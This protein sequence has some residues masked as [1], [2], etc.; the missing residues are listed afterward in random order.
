MPWDTESGGSYIWVTVCPR[1]L[2]TVAATDET[3]P[4]TCL[5]STG[6]ITNEKPS[7]ALPRCRTLLFPGSGHVLGILQE[8]YPIWWLRICALCNLTETLG[9]SVSY[10]KLHVVCGRWNVTKPDADLMPW[11][12]DPLEV[13]GSANVI[14]I[15]DLQGVCWQIKLVPE[16]RSEGVCL[17]SFPSLCSNL[18]SS[19]FS[20]FD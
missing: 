2:R 9:L 8:E 17:N 1:S 14:S 20:V 12:D 11:V 19:F 6:K 4:V 16:T 7:P 18:W 15:L 10:T 5:F 13:W 3:K